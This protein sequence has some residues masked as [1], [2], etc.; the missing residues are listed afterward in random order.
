[1]VAVTSD[2]ANNVSLTSSFL[3]SSIATLSV[4]AA[5]PVDTAGS[6]QATS[7]DFAGVSA[8]LVAA[9]AYKDGSFT[10]PAVDAYYGVLQVQV[11]VQNEEITSLSIPQYPSDRS[12]SR[13]IN[14]Q[15]LPLLRNEVVK[16]QTRERQ[17]RQ[18]RNADEQ[19]LHSVTSVR[20]RPGRWVASFKY[21]ERS[22]SEP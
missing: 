13:R 12:E 17:Y 9:T 15:A 14:Q 7:T 3:A 8:Q 11:V 6:S 5:Q 4:A 10:G 2:E 18:W 20:A 1:M 22:Q 21:A 16:A 19:S